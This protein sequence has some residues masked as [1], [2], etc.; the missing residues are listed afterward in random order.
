MCQGFSIP[1]FLTESQP[2]YLEFHKQSLCPQLLL[3]V[4][5]NFMETLFSCS[6]IKMVMCVCI[7]GSIICQSITAVLHLEFPYCKGLK[8]IEILRRMLAFDSFIYI[9][10]YLLFYWPCLKGET[11]S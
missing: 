10:I 1:S 7:F 9:F 11:Q 8:F 2:F 5:S 4:L 6:G 3:D